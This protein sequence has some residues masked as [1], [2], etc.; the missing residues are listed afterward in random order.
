VAQIRGGFQK[1]NERNERNKEKQKGSNLCALCA[2]AMSVFALFLTGCAVGPNFVRPGPPAVTQY[3]Q[4]PIFEQTVEAAG[5]A[6]HFEMGESV[7]GEWWRLFNSP[8]LDEVVRK[9]IDENRSLQSALLRLRQS[10]DVL[11]AGY[12]VFFPQVNA[13]FSAER[14]RFSLT[15]IGVTGQ[16]PLAQS[17][18]FPTS[19]LFNLYTFQ[20]TVSYV[21]DVFGGERRHVED[22][23]A[24]VEYQ[25]QTYRAASLTLVGNVVNA[26]IAQAG[27]R[28][29]IEAT[30][31][32]AGF[33]KEQLKI[34]EAQAEAGIAPYSNVLAIRTQLEST[35]ATLPPLQKNL[36]QAQHLL[37]ALVGKTPQQ[38]M[39]PSF[40]LTAITL[41][42]EIPVSV[43][44]E[45]T[46]RR[47][48]IL[49]AEAQLHSASAQIGVATA[50]MF[51]SLTLSGNYGWTSN[52]ITKLFT[53]GANVWS[54]ASNVAQ[55]IFNGGALWFQRRAAI[56]AYE[57][58]LFDYEQTVV[59]GFQQVADSLRALEFDAHTLR[60]QADSLATAKQNLDLINT[61]YES[62]IAT[63][64]QV[65]SADIQYQQARLGLIQA[66]AL[67]L[68]DTTALFV[69]LGGGWWDRACS[70]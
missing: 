46:H 47:P 16:N 13:N 60:A 50:A 61:N 35:E 41:P 52:D 48:D 34:A 24:Q 32:I 62:G 28:A 59:T 44:S 40:D 8:E 9:A 6:Q 58:S 70:Q 25:K 57:A 5:Q 42:V 11:C 68:Q 18:G 39:P 2:S 38:W 1:L 36:S 45:L 54:I 27:Y 49:A 69:A 64:L 53:P 23:A 17:I 7:A 4:E 37:A 22:L 3:T 66:R 55:P 26:V 56:Q 51:P 20:G 12:G 63:Y 10:R 33:Q 43:P 29:Q 67:R 14:E 31:E 30:E 65:L 21:V 19:T 15:Q